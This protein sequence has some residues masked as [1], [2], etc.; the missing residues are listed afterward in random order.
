MAKFI[1]YVRVST[2]RQGASG[3]GLEAQRAAV[4]KHAEGHTIVDEVREVE[5]GR[6]CDRRN[7]HEPSPYASST[8]PRSLWRS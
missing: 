7:L 3:L 4:A 1:G 6:R 5:S 8:R 2:Q